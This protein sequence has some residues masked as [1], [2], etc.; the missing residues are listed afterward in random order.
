MKNAAVIILGFVSGALIGFAYAQETKKSLADNV[1]T[2]FSDGKLDIT[3]DVETA[4]LQGLS[5]L[6]I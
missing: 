4:A 6:F 5:N 2:K 1:T 3:V